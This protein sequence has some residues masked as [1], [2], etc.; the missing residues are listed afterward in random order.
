MSADLSRIYQTTSTFSALKATFISAP[1]SAALLYRL[2]SVVFARNRII[3]QLIARV[4]L[5]I[6]GIDID[7]RATIDDGVL[8]QHPGGVVIGGGVHIGSYCTLMGGVTIGRKTLGYDDFNGYPKLGACVTV[9]ANATILGP[10]SIGNQTTI[11]ASAVAIKDT[12]DRSI[13][14]GNPARLIRSTNGEVEK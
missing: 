6:N 3:A 2:S 9:G 5:A 7:P 13:W 14:A 12:P 1:F 10:I 4:N 11:G 8:F